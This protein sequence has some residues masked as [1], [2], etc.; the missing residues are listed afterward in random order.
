MPSVRL[1]DYDK[2]TP[3]VSY[4]FGNISAGTTSTVKLAFADSYASGTASGTSFGISNVAGNDGYNF[5]Q[6][7]SATTFGASGSAISGSVL[8]TGGAIAATNPLQYALSVKDQWGWESE[9]YSA[10]S[11][12]PSLTSGTTT[13]LVALTWTAVSGA[14]TYGVYLSING[15]AAY[16]LIGYTANNYYTDT[17]GTSTA[18]D[19]QASG[20]VAYRAGT[21]TSGSVSLGDLASGT[22][23]PVMYKE[24]IPSG[25]SST[26]NPRQHYIYVSYLTV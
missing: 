11:F 21:W 26:G 7:T 8:T 22:Q 13:H 16:K 6:I 18:T 12:A 3:F 23:V 19:P 14:A 17:S 2:T 15:G 24:V 9:L 1:L 25:T 20:S 10:T 5:A 4:S